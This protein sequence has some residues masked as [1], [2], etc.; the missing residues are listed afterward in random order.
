MTKFWDLYSIKISLA[1]FLLV[2]T[3]SLVSN[4]QASGFN[5][6]CPNVYGAQC[7]TTSLVVDKKIQHPQSGEL[8]DTLSSSSV[9]FLPGQ[10]VNFRIEVRNAGNSNV[11][12]VHAWDKLPDYVDFV[13][14]P[15]NYD[16]NAHGLWWAVDDLRAGESKQ[17]FVKV[18]VRAQEN[19]P[20]LNLTCVTN[21]VEA[22]RDSLMAQDT[23]SFCIQSKVLGAVKV[24]PK[25]GMSIFNILLTTTIASGALSLFFARKSNKIS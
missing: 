23:A 21:F 22:K 18:K 25:T 16:S 13:S 11:S 8:L 5:S 9:T 6:D 2:A 3:L 12:G 20:E 1:L 19:L 7:P 15:G 17:Y 4:V 14:G 10:E 24:L